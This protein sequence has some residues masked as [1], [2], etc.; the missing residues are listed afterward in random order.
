MGLR[1]GISAP[2][3]ENGFLGRRI[4][5]SRRLRRNTQGEIVNIFNVR[6]MPG[7]QDGKSS[8]G[9]AKVL[10]GAWKQ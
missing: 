6:K 10:G 5:S 8:A 1:F 7:F 2:E 4:V 3:P 9:P